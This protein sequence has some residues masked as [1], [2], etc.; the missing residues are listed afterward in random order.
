MNVAAP[1]PVNGRPEHLTLPDKPSIAVLAFTNMSGDPEQEYF[2]DG[3]A[4]DI[5]TE[6]SRMRWLFVIARNT[7]F[8]YKGH[9][10]DVKQVGRELGV[11]YVLEGSVRRGGQ[12]VRVTAQ[13]IDAE[14][15]NHVW[16]ERYDRDLADV[17]AVQDEI[18]L[19]VTRAIGPA[20]ADA[21][22][23]RAL[24]KPPE[25][26]GGW[27]AYQRGLWHLSQK[28]LEDVPHARS[29]FYRALDLDP[30]LAAAHT[31]LAVLYHIESGLFV[32]RPLVEGLRMAADEA[33]KAV[34][35]DPTDAE[36]LA[37]RAFAVGIA[38]DFARGF[39]HVER[40]LSINPNCVLAYRAK[41]WLLM[42]SGRPTEG[43]EAILFAMRID[44]R[45]TLD[46]V[47]Q[48][49]IV[50][51][52]YMECDYESAVATAR[53]LM[54]DRP[55]H[56]WPY[57]WMAAALGQLG[58]TAEA[59]DVLDRAIATAPDAFHLFV[60]QR[61]PWTRQVDYD[62]MLDGLRKAGWQG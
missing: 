32:K 13:L 34:E 60:R 30:T 8:T 62:H 25:N 54:A 9:A 24:R 35:I 2:S 26:L 10:I 46:V 15:G 61:V 4:D 45:S 59:R 21:E 1:A 20:V 17:F 23:R 5:I 44:P 53:R 57:R 12:R 52:Y 50:E 28:R 47:P 56:P 37:Y 14:S 48:S 49:H 40:A 3:I 6:L 51:T 7:S 58:R 27:E 11:R 38:G 41:G 31:G 22:Q 16:A 39:D 36:A 55:D 19:A 42:N 43:R 18:T 29:Y 33:R